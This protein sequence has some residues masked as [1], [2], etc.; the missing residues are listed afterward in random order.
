MKL[1][2]KVKYDIVIISPHMDDA[3]LSLGQHIIEW[4]RQNKTVK[5]VTVFT[6]FLG[7][8]LP[9][10]SREYINK[11]GFDNAMDF[12]KERVREDVKAMKKMEVEY[13]HW[14]YVDAGFRGNYLTKEEL[15]N[16]KIKNVDT[17]LI[18]KISK[19]ICEIKASEIYLPYGVG[20]HVDH[21]IVRR[22][23]ERIDKNVSF[24]LEI[25]YLWQNFNYLIYLN[26]IFSI[27]SLKMG[28]IV[29]MNV[30]KCYKSQYGLL[31]KFNKIFTEVII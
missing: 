19:K 8:N 16:G 20:G 13:E 6:K 23:G 31:T 18:D 3:A 30:L 24:Y 14:G 5:V 2:K 22:A 27:K 7:K 10:Y 26:K 21:L 9:E 12:E 28:D 4:K 1:V 11:S 29:K 15:L 17:N 25:P